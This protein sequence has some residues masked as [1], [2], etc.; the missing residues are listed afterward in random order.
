[1]ET[2][3]DVGAKRVQELGGRAGYKRGINEKKIYICERTN[4]F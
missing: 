4:I 3:V 1:M 2:E